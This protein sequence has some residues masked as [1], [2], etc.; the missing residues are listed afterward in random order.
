MNKSTQTEKLFMTQP[1]DRV[2]EL[3]NQLWLLVRENKNTLTRWMDNLFNKCEAIE[4]Q[5][6]NNQKQISNNGKLIE[7]NEELISIQQKEISNNGKLI[8]ILDKEQTGIVDDLMD[9]INE[10]NDKVDN[11]KV[12]LRDELLREV[13]EEMRA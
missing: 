10:L 11:M 5:I 2:V 3:Y 8:E 4:K 12:E 1:V 6:S 7:N 13:R 9:E